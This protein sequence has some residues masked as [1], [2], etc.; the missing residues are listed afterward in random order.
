MNR[1]VIVTVTARP[2]RT[3][4]VT[5]TVTARNGNEFCGKTTVIGLMRVLDVRPAAPAPRGPAAGK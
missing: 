5:Y 2:A 3:P 4:A 1:V